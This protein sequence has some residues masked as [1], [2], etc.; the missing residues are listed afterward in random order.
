MADLPMRAYYFAF[1]PTGVRAIDEILSAV[2][3]AG[4]A[5]PTTP[6]IGP[7]Q[8][9]KGAPW[10]EIFR[11][12]LIERQ[13]PQAPTAPPPGRRRSSPGCGGQQRRRIP[14]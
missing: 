6:R 8:T 10:R 1:C 7:T 5:Y 13:K 12:Q 4:K 2:A 9:K 3:V 11:S 14:R